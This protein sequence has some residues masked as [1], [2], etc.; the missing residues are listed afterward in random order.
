MIWILLLAPL[1]IVALGGLGQ[2]LASL[3]E[4][5]HG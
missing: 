4:D 2:Y 3:D 5:D 1:L